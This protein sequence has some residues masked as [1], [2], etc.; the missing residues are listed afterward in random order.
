ML[1]A[2]QQPQIQL[3]PQP[4]WAV[5]AKRTATPVF[6][7]I[8]V[9]VVIGLQ[10]TA[11]PRRRLRIDGQIGRT[12]LCAGRERIL[13]QRTWDIAEQQQASFERIAVD[14]SSTFQA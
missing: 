8:G 14:N 4:Q 2:A 13:Y 7:G 12:G 9:A 11:Q 1:I 3:V 6:A 5:G 10:R